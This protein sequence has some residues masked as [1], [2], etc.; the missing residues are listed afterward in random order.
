MT[1]SVRCGQPRASAC[2]YG[3]SPLL[4]A[5]AVKRC[6]LLVA[7]S[8]WVGEQQG[9]AHVLSPRLIRRGAPSWHPIL[10]RQRDQ[11]ER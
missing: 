5:L 3:P 10:A 8:G 11:H 1:C 2:G 7:S 9:P 4:S 6:A